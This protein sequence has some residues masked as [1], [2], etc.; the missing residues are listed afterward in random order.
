M[1]LASGLGMYLIRLILENFLSVGLDER[2]VLS[3]PPE[4]RGAS[5]SR[6][7]PLSIFG[8]FERLPIPQVQLIC[9][10]FGLL[11][12]GATIILILGRRYRDGFDEVNEKIRPTLKKAYHALKVF[13]ENLRIE[14]VELIQDEEY[15]IFFYKTCLY[16]VP[17]IVILILGWWLLGFII[18]WLVNIFAWVGSSFIVIADLTAYSITWIGIAQP[19]VGWLVLGCLSGGVLGLIQALKRINQYSYL[20]KVYKIAVAIALILVLTACLNWRLKP[21]TNPFQKIVVQEDFKSPSN[22]DIDGSRAIMK[23]GG[24]FHQESNQ[25]SWLLS[26]WD[27]HTFKDVDF[28]VDTLKINSPDD[29]AFGIFAHYGNENSSISSGDFYYLLITGN[30]KFAMGKYLASNKWENKVGWQKST[31]IKRGNERNRLRIVCNKQKVIGWINDQRVGMFEDDSYNLGQIG[32]ISG[33]GNGDA[34]AVYFDNVLA[35]EKPE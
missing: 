18:N 32:V 10:I 8:I 13:I 14:L 35:K 1:S 7:S 16:L 29:I 31:A 28:S 23:D 2:W 3:Y 19:A 33:R 34:V 26:V 30:G 24:L 11:I 21:D 15:L 22:W 17:I 20:P 27:G 6:I 9:S 25:N 4:V 5:F 12:M